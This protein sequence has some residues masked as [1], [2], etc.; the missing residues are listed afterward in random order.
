MV[1]FR[2]YCLIPVFCLLSLA[3]TP[4]V[5]GK[6]VKLGQ[7]TVNHGL[8]R[9]EISVTVKEG[10][11]DKIKLKVKRRKVTFRDLKVHFG[12]GDVQDVSLRRAIP[13]GGETRSIELSGQGRR[14]IKKVVFWYNTKRVRGKR[15][16]VE[17]WGWR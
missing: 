15:A 16:V 1:K 2:W 6:W 9:D 4:D 10:V 14:V 13:A 12:S 7:R 11:F 3:S 5:F 8:D 17:L